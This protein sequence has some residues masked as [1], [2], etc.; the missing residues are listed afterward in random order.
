MLLVYS[1]F[2]DVA[3]AA[4]KHLCGTQE[5]LNIFSEACENMK[6]CWKVVLDVH[7]ASIT[8]VDCRRTGSLHC[9]NVI[10]FPLK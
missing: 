6:M 5:N 7:P 4:F 8:W 9:S 3:S 2:S 1:I 10:P